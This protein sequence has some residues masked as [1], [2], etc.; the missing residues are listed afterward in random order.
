MNI[1]KYFVFLFILFISSCSSTVTTTNSFSSSDAAFINE[2]GQAIINGQAFLRRNDGI[3]VYAA[4]S[5]VILVPSTTYSQER[6]TAIYQGK[7]AAYLLRNVKFENDSAEYKNYIKSTK[8]DGEGKFEFSDLA[9][10]SY[11]IVTQVFWTPDPN[12]IFPEGAKLLEKVT[13]T[14]DTKNIKVIITGT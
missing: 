5:D 13:I 7:K 3:V 10:G 1:E 9:P 6:M 4:G 12:A 14:K 2:S 11:F 8:A